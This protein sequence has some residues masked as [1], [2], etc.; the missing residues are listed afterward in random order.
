MTGGTL[1]D[2]A[3]TLRDAYEALLAKV[4][5][6]LGY[7]DLAELTTAYQDYT[8]TYVGVL[9]GT[10]SA[11]VLGVT[12]RRFVEVMSRLADRHDTGDLLDDATADYF[13]DFHDACGRLDGNVPD[14]ES[15]VSVAAATTLLSWLQSAARAGLRNDAEAPADPF[16]FDHQEQADE[17]RDRT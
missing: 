2:T 15:L 14:L 6:A 17:Q 5:S 16:H 3:E 9:S 8:D 11:D 10:V 1:L 4:E 12:S 13:A 7:D